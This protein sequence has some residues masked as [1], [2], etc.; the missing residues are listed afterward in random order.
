M[1]TIESLETEIL[2]LHR[3]YT[4]LFVAELRKLADLENQSTEVQEAQPLPSVSF[5]PEDDAPLSRL[6]DVDLMEEA[7]RLFRQGKRRHAWSPE[8]ELQL[9]SGLRRGLTPTDLLMWVPTKNIEQIRSK[10]KRIR[11]AEKRQGPYF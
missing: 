2:Q 6:P 7:E 5:P 1:N 10:C 4:S 9:R 11:Q 3:T 8:E